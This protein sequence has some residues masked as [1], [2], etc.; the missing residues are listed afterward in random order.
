MHSYEGYDT[1][2]GALAHA[3]RRRA[4]PGEPADGAPRARARARWIDEL[5]AR[6]ERLETY[7][8]QARFALAGSYDR[9]TD[10]AAA[11]T[12]ALQ[13][14]EERREVRAS[15]RRRAGVAARCELRDRA[16]QRHARRSRWVQPDVAEVE[17]ADSLDLAA[18]SYR[19]Y[20]DET[21]MSEMTPEAMRRFADLQLE[22]SSASPV[23]R[24]RCA[25]WRWRRPIPVRRRAR[26]AQPRP[27]APTIAD[28]IAGPWRESDDEFELRTTGE[29]EFE[30]AA[31]SICRCPGPSASRSRGRSSH[32]DLRALAHRVP[33]LRAPRPGALPNGARLRRAR[34]DGRGDGGHA[35]P[36][37]RV[38]LLAL[39]RRGAVSPRRV[40]LHAAQVP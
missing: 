7:E 19:R 38:R 2:L 5:V 31:V 30:P 6:R 34:P 33:E 36:G 16:R 3:R 4:W 20:L 13:P 8:D 15:I 21:P 14:T 40:L 29:I 39:Q 35:A 22:R 32:R 1:P 23:D 28:A 9:A 12:A 18:Q 17:V 37:R 25:G 26:S 27:L 11:E 24:P 10:R